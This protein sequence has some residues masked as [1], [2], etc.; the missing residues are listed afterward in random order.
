MLP[1]GSGRL[2]VDLSGLY[3]VAGKTVLI[4]GGV[5]GIGRMLAEG[6]AAGGATLIITGRKP[7]ALSEAVTALRATGAD[8]RGVVADLASPEGVA[9]VADGLRQHTDRLDVLINNAGQTWGAPLPDFPAK[10]WAP[11]M[12][13]NVQAPFMLVQ[14]LLPVLRAAASPGAPARVLNIGSVYAQTTEVALAYSYTA[15]KAAIHQL[16]RVLA[17]DLAGDHVLCNAIAPGL[18]PSKMTGF[19]LRDEE[20]K[21]HTLS[22]IPLGRPGTAEDIAG[23]AIFLCSRA[24]AYITG[25]VIPIDGGLLI[26]H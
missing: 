2:A 4:T 6:F 12:A 10:A 1:D 22:G 25:A 5:G 14:A 16:T 24:G 3:S 15:S 9:A 18:F 19:I 26:A 17:R 7:D 13:V 23:L 11:V 20:R 21:A 8:V